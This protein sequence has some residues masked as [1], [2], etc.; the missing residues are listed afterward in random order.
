M[1]LMVTLC[2]GAAIWVVVATAGVAAA[3]MPVAPSASAAI[4]VATRVFRVDAF[5][6]IKPFVQQRLV[7]GQQGIGFS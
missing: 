5:I 2:D 3:K 1:S 4:A 7:P 6:V